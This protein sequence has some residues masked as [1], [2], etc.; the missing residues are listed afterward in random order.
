MSQ[1]T[2]LLFK[3]KICLKDN[4]ELIDYNS[5]KFLINRININQS[6]R[7]V[8]SQN[9]AYFKEKST[10][11]KQNEIELLK[12]IKDSKNDRYFINTGENSKDINKL[13][14]EDPAYLVYN[15]SFFSKDSSKKEK[16]FYKLSEGDIIKIGRVFI[17]ILKIQL[18][19]KEKEIN[20][21]N[22]NSIEIPNKEI[23]YTS[24]RK[25]LSCSSHFIKE[26]EVIKGSNNRLYY[27]NESEEERNS[28][29][30][31]N[32]RRKMNSTNK[33]ILPKVKSINNIYKSL[34]PF[35]IKSKNQ[36]NL[37]LD[38][39]ENKEIILKI[40]EK[41]K[42]KKIC[43]IC[44]GE[45]DKDDS[46]NPLISPCICNGSMKY[47]HYKCLRNWL[48]SKID[49]SPLS[50]IELKDNIGMCYCT[51]IFVCELCK[52]KFP[53]YIN[54]NGKLF[55]LTF[56][57]T[58]F[59][60]FLIFQS[61]QIDSNNK[62]FIHI[63]SFYKRNKLSIGRSNDCDIL[64]P[65]HSISRHHCFIHY[66]KKSERLFLE[67]NS[68]RYGSL[69]LIQNPFLLMINKLSLN[70]QKN[71]TYIKI[72]LSIPFGL[73]SC[74]S[75]STYNSEKYKSYQEQNEPYLNSYNSMVIK[76]NNHEIEEYDYYKEEEKEIKNQ[77]NTNSINSIL[78]KN[79]LYLRRIKSIDYSK[80]KI[81]KNIFKL[82]SNNSNSKNDDTKNKILNNFETQKISINGNK[83]NSNNE[84]INLF[85]FNIINNISNK[86]ENNEN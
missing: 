86:K 77:R 55:N 74:C 78:N 71:K 43:R 16:I 44:F 18:R 45:N 59:E 75:I 49:S 36:L 57:K 35:K 40:K 53:D 23:N 50:S 60:K 14:N 63:L 20:K 62:S 67:D 25:N 68:S 37:G 15:N 48:D 27:N 17:K 8:R 82:N 19:K 66:D 31:F 85:S 34:F 39:N 56:Y 2:S 9:D 7:L 58:E 28:E 69:I 24:V 70:I 41:Y 54:F 1:N 46:E 26:Q 11:L 84:N 83:F 73:F 81:N 79:K 42:H 10:K 61:I 38:K 76:N 32:I 5:T 52:T 80:Y 33:L 64:F 47:I 21:I 3:I 72:K 30:I 51:D 12:I 6:G 13:I 65:E 22:N 4:L 29:N